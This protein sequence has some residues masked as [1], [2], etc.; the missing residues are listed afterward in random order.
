MR[1]ANIYYRGLE[2]LLMQDATRINKRDTVVCKLDF[3]KG[4]HVEVWSIDKDGRV[5]E[6]VQTYKCSPKM[7]KQLWMEKYLQY[8]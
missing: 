3:M 2:I 6:C 4:S 1:Y 7:R 8:A 5:I